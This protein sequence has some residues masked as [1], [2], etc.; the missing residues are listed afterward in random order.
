[1]S[2]TIDLGDEFDADWIGLIDEGAPA[3]DAWD[4]ANAPGSIKAK[5][6]WDDDYVE[7]VNPSGKGIVGGT[8]S[9]IVGY[10]QSAQDLYAAADFYAWGI[11][12]RF[13]RFTVKE[14]VGAT[15]IY[16]E[17]RVVGAGVLQM[18][19]SEVRETFD[20]N[21]MIWQLKCELLSSLTE[22]VFMPEY[23]RIIG[24]GPQVV[25]L[26]IE[27]L[28]EEVD[29]WFWALTSIVGYDHGAGAETMQEAAERWIAWY[30]ALMGDE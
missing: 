27:S 16:N 28:R 24:L 12:H 30:D 1:M 11:D 13:P 23:Q 2:D 29:H 20:H 15:K 8:K 14:R 3:P 17:K 4:S 26:I 10:F 19:A 18:S 6:G 9:A 25:P 21:R 22:I 7:R 5:F